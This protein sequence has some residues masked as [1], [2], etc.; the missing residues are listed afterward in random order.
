LLKLFVTH[1]E[2]IVLKYCTLCHVADMLSKTIVI[3]PTPESSH[4]LLEG[5]S[6]EMICRAESTDGDD[7]CHLNHHVSV[8]QS[9]SARDSHSGMIVRVAVQKKLMTARSF[10]PS[11]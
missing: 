6:M 3:E 7:F 4:R 8:C 10:S 2:C 5:A 11:Q 9:D 1:I